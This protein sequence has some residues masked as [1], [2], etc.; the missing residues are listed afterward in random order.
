MGVLWLYII[1]LNKSGRHP[2]L[3]T[4]DSRENLLS[5]A[6]RLNDIKF[7]RLILLELSLSLF[8]SL[9]LL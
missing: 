5:E 8:S 6:F 4:N 1:L 9:L 2:I 3:I 7:Y